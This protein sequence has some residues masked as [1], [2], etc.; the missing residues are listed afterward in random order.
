ME[1]RLRSHGAAVRE[2]Q[3][4]DGK[5]QTT[6]K[7]NDN[8]EQDLAGLLV[9][10]AEDGVEVAQEEG[11]GEAEADADK[12]PV[13]D[14][15]GGPADA[16]D[17]Q[18]NEVGVAVESPALEQVGEL[19]AKVAQGEEQDDG[20]DEGV[21]VD[22]A[23]GAAQQPEV[24]GKGGVMLG[25]Q[26]L[27]DGA[28]EEEDEN[29]RGG[30]P[31]GPVEVRVAVEN[32]E[33]VCARVERGPAARQYGRGIDVEELGVEGH[34]PEEALRGAAARG[35]GRY[36]GR[37]AAGRRLAVGRVRVVEVGVVEFEVLLEIGVAEVTI[38]VDID[39]GVVSGA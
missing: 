10:G 24:I 34:G 27:A 20:D 7:G 33:E 29:D 25:R 17:G 9:G 36:G 15:D 22:E 28:A 8:D 19:A 4:L 18:P 21:A 13:E 38:I 31:K 26:V 2:E 37:E 11:N 30:N 16:G 3:N 14:A 1:T 39:Y 35:G 6:V 12:D 32:V 23:G 5:R